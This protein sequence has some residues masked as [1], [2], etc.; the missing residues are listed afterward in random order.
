MQPWCLLAQNVG[1]QIIGVSPLTTIT[2]RFGRYADAL[3]SG[4]TGI[5]TVVRT[6]ASGSRKTN[7]AKEHDT[8]LKVMSYEEGDMVGEAQAKN[9]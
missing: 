7:K 3:A 8:K 2:V 1:R 6:P 9:H 4:A 5:R